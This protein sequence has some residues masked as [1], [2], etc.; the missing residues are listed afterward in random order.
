[1]HTGLAAYLNY[2]R[3]MHLK[4]QRIEAEIEEEIQRKYGPLVPLANIQR[5]FAR[6]GAHTGG[7]GG[8]VANA[9]EAASHETATDREFVVTA[10][11]GVQVRGAG[12]RFGVFGWQ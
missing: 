1:M 7:Q 4:R 8:P 11:R 6:Q 10:V 3:L 2:I 5:G 9:V 12:G